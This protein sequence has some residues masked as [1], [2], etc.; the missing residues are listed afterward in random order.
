MLRCATD[1]VAVVRLGR[2]LFLC[3]LLVIGYW[4]SAFDW[5]LAIGS[6]P[7]DGRWAIGD[8]QWAIGDWRLAIGYR[9]LAIGY[10]LPAVGYWALAIGCV[11]LA[12][13][14]WRLAM[15]TFDLI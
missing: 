15:T 12:I 5:V 1:L 13:G 4:L 10:W 14:E 9:L 6:W 3:R 8:G 2:C 7:G 11:L